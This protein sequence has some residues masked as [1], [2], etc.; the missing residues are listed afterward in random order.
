[1]ADLYVLSLALAE[2]ILRSLVRTPTFLPARLHTSL[3]CLLK[4]R[5]WSIVSPNRPMSEPHFI[6]TFAIVL[7]F[8]PLAP[9][10]LFGTF[11][12][13]LSVNLTRTT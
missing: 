2:S 12:T 10:S 13:Y 7:W 8:C 5:F 3:T 1:M 9:Y 11:H 4:S 6:F